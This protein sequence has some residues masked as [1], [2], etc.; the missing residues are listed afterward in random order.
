MGWETERLQRSIERS[1][2]NRKTVTSEL[3]KGTLLVYSKISNS[4]CD[5]AA[6]TTELSLLRQQPMMTTTTTIKTAATIIAKAATATHT[7]SGNH[8]QDNGNDLDIACSQTSPSSSIA[9]RSV[10]GEPMAVTLIL[11]SMSCGR[12]QSESL[13]SEI[14]N[15]SND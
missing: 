6:C 13:L 7:G 15:F 2:K 3:L 10:S 14:S 4:N 11:A 1:T 5:N 12:R 9:S 8:K